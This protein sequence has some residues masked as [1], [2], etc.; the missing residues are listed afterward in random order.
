MS[1]ERRL[2]TLERMTPTAERVQVIHLVPMG[3]R[4][5]PIRRAQVCGITFDRADDETER[6]FLARVKAHIPAHQQRVILAF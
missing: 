4:E 3:K 6:S 5:C 1:L 2:D